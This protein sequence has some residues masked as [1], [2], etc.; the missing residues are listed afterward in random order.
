MAF[1]LTQITE[2]TEMLIET[3]TTGAFNKSALE[4]RPDPKKA[5]LNTVDACNKL[6]VAFS[7]Q[8]RETMDSTGC[9]IDMQFGIK[10]DGNGSV[11]IAK[12]MAGCQFRVAMAFKSSDAPVSD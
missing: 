10:V 6:G 7:D 3:E 8:L 5:F 4:V 9:S 1:F 11:M 2:D 12:E